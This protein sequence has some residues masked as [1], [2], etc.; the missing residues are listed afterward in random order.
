MQHRI[1]QLLP[2]RLLPLQLRL[3][4]VALVHQSVGGGDDVVVPF[5]DDQDR[6]FI[7]RTFKNFDFQKLLT[8]RMGEAP[9]EHTWHPHHAC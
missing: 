5:G 3:Q 2:E 4:R 9:S 1:Q 7:P 8:Q 6:L